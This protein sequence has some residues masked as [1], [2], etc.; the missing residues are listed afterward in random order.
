ML[1]NFRLTREIFYS[2]W[3]VTITGKGPQILNKTLHSWPISSE[4]SLSA[5]TTV[6]WDICILWLSRRTRD[7]DTCCRPFGSGAKSH[8]GI[9]P[10][11]PTWEWGY[12]GNDDET[13]TW[14]CWGQAPSCDHQCSILPSSH[15]STIHFSM[16]KLRM[17]QTLKVKYWGHD[18]WRSTLLRHHFYGR[19]N[20]IS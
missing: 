20:M 1:G 19:T 12:N 3:D 10:R 18:T 17:V 7:I 6:T 4:G 14:C 2:Y 13:K 9:K 5:T 11:S 8:F 16:V 15:H